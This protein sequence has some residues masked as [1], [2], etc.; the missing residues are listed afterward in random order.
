MPCRNL[1]PKSVQMPHPPLWV[2]CSKRET[3]L[4]AA[5]HSIGAI[6]FAFID[7]SEAVKWVAENY[8]I[9]KSNVRC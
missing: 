8:D 6:I 9:I 3:I 1:V 2:A 4:Q 5:R 7:H